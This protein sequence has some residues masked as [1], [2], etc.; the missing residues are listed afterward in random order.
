MNLADVSNELRDWAFTTLGG[1]SVIY[2][3]TRASSNVKGGN[4]IA[5]ATERASAGDFKPFLVVEVDRPRDAEKGLAMLG[6]APVEIW[7]IAPYGANTTDPMETI[8]DLFETLIAALK[9]KTN[10]LASPFNTFQW[11]GLTPVVDTNFENSV[12]A[13]FADLKLQCTGGVLRFE[14]FVDV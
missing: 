14:V 3:T 6:L 5:D 2:K 10:N 8:D 9:T 4:W 13:K 1:D 7:I 11:N 12:Q